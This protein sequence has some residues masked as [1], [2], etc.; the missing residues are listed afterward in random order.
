MRGDQT[1]FDARMDQ[2]GIVVR[3]RPELKTWEDVVQW[4]RGKIV[5]SALLSAD[6]KEGRALWLQKQP[7]D[8]RPDF[9]NV[10]VDREGRSG[11]S[12]R[13]ESGWR[14]AGRRARTLRER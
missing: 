4:A 2:H 8:W 7:A 3:E 9:D 10:P 1:S 6:G 11:A 14:G 13:R 12:L 5:E